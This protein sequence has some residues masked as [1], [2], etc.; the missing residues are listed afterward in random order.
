[1]G[2]N[3]TQPAFPHKPW[4]WAFSRGNVGILTRMSYT[5]FIEDCVLCDVMS[6]TI[7]GALTVY[8]RA[9]GKT[10]CFNW[11][12]SASVTSCIGDLLR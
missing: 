12:S 2:G 4:K 10:G 11:L 7:T 5:Q 6:Q 3:L 8:Q 1:M 9:N